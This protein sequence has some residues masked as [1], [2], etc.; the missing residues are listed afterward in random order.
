MSRDHRSGDRSRSAGHSGKPTDL[1][2]QIA[3]QAAS[4]R[5][6]HQA[7]N[8]TVRHRH[9]GPKQ[10]GAWEE[11]VRQ[12]HAHIQALYGPLYEAMDRLA[13]GDQPA[14]EMAVTFLELDPYCFRSGYLK[15]DLIRSLVRVEL[16]AEHASRLRDVVL[17]AVDGFDRR[18]SRSYCRLA[19]KVAT[20][21]LRRILSSRLENENPGVRRRARWVLEALEQS[22]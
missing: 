6:A 19:R 12:F 9:E 11:A 3:H 1:R 20:P 17:A 8:A 21:E 4:V 14:V 13:A 5:E 7:V 16:P 22:P 2:S 15:A 18:E 10:R